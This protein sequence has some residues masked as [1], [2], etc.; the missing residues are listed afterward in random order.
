MNVTTA[1]ELGRG[2]GEAGELTLGDGAEQTTLTVLG[3]ATLGGAGKS[4]VFA[5]G[6]L[7]MGVFGDLTLG[8]FLGSQSN[9]NMNGDATLFRAAQLGVE[10]TLNIGAEGA[11]ALSLTGLAV[12][13]VDALRAGVFEGGEGTLNLSKADCQ[14]DVT[15]AAAIGIDGRS[16]YQR[17]NVKDTDV[18]GSRVW[19]KSVVQTV[20]P[21][22]YEPS[23]SS[24][25]PLRAGLFLRLR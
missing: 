20:T 23:S 1:L 5:N 25:A 9:L 21:W 8:L 16:S 7:N 10:G 6:N 14:L 18:N 19:R 24:R 15:G 17:N 4:T 13:T 12:G 2:I 3:D 22:T 11:G